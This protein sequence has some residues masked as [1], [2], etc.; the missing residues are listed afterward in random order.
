MW[1]H[2]DL[3]T[4]TAARRQTPKDRRPAQ[5]GSHDYGEAGKYRAGITRI[6]STECLLDGTA[7]R[8]RPPSRAAQPVPQNSLIAGSLVINGAGPRLLNT[9]VNYEISVINNKYC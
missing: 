4:A 9:I 8:G 5:R 3:T 6:R 7:P 1:L 2:G